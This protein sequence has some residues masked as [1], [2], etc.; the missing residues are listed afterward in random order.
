MVGSAIVSHLKAAGHTNLVTATHAALDLIDQK[1]VAHFFKQEKPDYV[2]LAA[3][4]VGGILANNDYPAQFIYDNLMVQTNVIHQSHCHKV[5][6][7]LFLGSSC[8]Y[9]KHAPQ[10]ISE[11]HLLTGEL[12]PTNEPYAIAKI[13]GLKMCHAYNRQYKT[14]YI[15]VMPTNLYGP[16]DNYDL[17]T[18]HVL[19]A[20]IR[21]FHLAR[22]AVQNDWDAIQKDQKIF[23]AIPEDVM[24]NLKTIST[25]PASATFTLWG[26]GAPYREW[27]H[28]E[29]MADACLFI[30]NLDS[31]RSDS[32]QITSEAPLFNIGY[33]KD[34]TIKELALKVAGIVGYTGAIGWDHLKPDGMPRK[35]LNVS[36]LNNIGWTP[37]IKLTQ[38]IKTTYA[39][40][41]ARSL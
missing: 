17:N 9:P 14:R 33:G 26:T 6:M 29:D 13:A 7:L 34:I 25:N 31:N 1:A 8:I 12:E 41:L 4:K 24:A 36:Q 20:L 23:G 38:G 15:P 5:K 21:K 28:V 10:P 11:D 22:L 19:P 40:Y 3:A 27:L 18:S 35:L 16:N 37:K 2:F 30:M 39:T 32:E